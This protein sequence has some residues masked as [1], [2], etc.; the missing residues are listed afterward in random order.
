MVWCI[1]IGHSF[2]YFFS[3]YVL[4]HNGNILFNNIFFLNSPKSKTSKKEKKP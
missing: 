1:E 2:S 3:V 4:I